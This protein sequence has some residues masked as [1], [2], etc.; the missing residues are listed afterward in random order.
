MEPNLGKSRLATNQPVC[1]AVRPTIFRGHLLNEASDPPRQWA[2]SLW[3]GRQELC[4]SNTLPEILADWQKRAALERVME[5][6][7][8]AVNLNS[9][10]EI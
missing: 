9:A 3:R 7:D 8:E 2:A 1:R 4:K 5:V 10:F 6:L